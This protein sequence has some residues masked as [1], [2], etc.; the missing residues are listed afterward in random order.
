MFL[1][2]KNIMLKIRR[3]KV[4]DYTKTEHFSKFY[5]RHYEL[6]VRYNVET[7]LQQGISFILNGNFVYKF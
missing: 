4:T 1:K 6:I 7:H 2:N 5:H 3:S